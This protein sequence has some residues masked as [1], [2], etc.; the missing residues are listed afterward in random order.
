MAPGIKTGGRKKGSLNKATRTR[1][2]VARTV[3]ETLAQL[4]R[5]GRSMAE[6]QIDAARYLESLAAEERAKPKPQQKEIAELLKAASKIA[7][8]ISPYLYA[9][10]QT[11]RRGGEEDAAPIRME[12]LS[13]HQLETLIARLRKG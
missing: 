6:I 1:R 2:A 3:A 8:S 11:L 5:S 13:D 4:D 9:T 7:N 12:T 10:H